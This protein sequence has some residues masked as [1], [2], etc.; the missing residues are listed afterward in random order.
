MY[1]SHVIKSEQK[2]VAFIFKL[3]KTIDNGVL[4]NLPVIFFSFENVEIV[5]L[6]FVTGTQSVTVLRAANEEPS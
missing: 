2:C 3:R 6:L 4:A 5:S 1:D